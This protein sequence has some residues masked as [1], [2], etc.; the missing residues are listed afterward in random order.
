[1]KLP[2]TVEKI[3]RNHTPKKCETL[4]GSQYKILYVNGKYCMCRNFPKQKSRCQN[5]CK[6]ITMKKKERIF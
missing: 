1:M 4:I 2:T 3:L 6:K 5:A